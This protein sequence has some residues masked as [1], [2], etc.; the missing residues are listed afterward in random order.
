MANI[1]AKVTMVA[2]RYPIIVFVISFSKATV[3]DMMM[4]MKVVGKQ[5]II[6]HKI[7]VYLLGGL[8]LQEMTMRQYKKKQICWNVISHIYI[9]IHMFILT[10]VSMDLSPIVVSNFELVHIK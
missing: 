1:M 8:K 4:A 5:L 10:F 3:Y 9:Y 2:I 6:P 7:S